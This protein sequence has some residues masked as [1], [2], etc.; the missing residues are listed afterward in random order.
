VGSRSS[1]QSSSNGFPTLTQPPVIK[2]VQQ[3]DGPSKPRDP[4]FVQGMGR[5]D[6]K[7]GTANTNEDLLDYNI[8]LDP[9]GAELLFGR[10][11]SESSL[12]ERMRQENKNRPQAEKVMFPE[13]PV[14]SNQPFMA[15]TFPAQAIFAEP[16]YVSYHRLYTEDKNVER[17]GWE[18]GI[19]QPIVSTAGFYKDVFFLPAKIAS[20]PHRRYDASAGQC[21]PGDP[22]PYLLYPPEITW[23]GG[24]VQIGTIVGL[25]GVIP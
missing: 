19:L 16:N 23:Q 24:L 12:M 17:Y 22:I 21:L 18:L 2:Q 6:P 5:T 20:Y 9:P 13:K 14:L 1:A 7:Y 15:R 3:L 4:L 25:Y 8:R 11:D 10:L